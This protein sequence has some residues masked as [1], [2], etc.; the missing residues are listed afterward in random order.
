MK[1]RW[2]F[3]LLS[4]FCTTLYGQTTIGLVAYYSFE[5]SLEDVT[6]N[7]A[8]T[9][10]PSGEVDYDC[11]VEGEALFLDGGGDQVAFIEQSASMPTAPVT[12]EFDTEDF[13]VSM[14]FKSTGLGGTQVLL[15]KQRLDCSIDNAFF[16]RY[17]PLNRTLSVY[18]GESPSQN[19]ILTQRVPADLCWQHIAVVRK[20]GANKLYL[21]ASLIGE[22]TSSKRINIFNDGDLIL[23]GSDCLMGTETNFEGLIDEFRVYNRALDLE[24]IRTLYNQPD[25]II[26]QDTIIFLGNGVDINISNICVDQFAWTPQEGVADPFEPQTNIEPATAGDFIYKL[27]FADN[28][29]GCVAVDSIQIS[30]IDPKDLDCESIFIPNAFTPNNVGPFK[31]ETFGIS[32]PFAIPELLSF[33]IFDR[34][35]NRVFATAD[36]F[37]RWDG[38]YKGTAVNPGVMLYKLQYR[39]NGET[40]FKAGSLTV[41]R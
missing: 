24:E 36:P 38:N 39:C 9:G 34:W 21:N 10:F 4:V 33:E 31:N 37:Q 8:N 17:I 20:A 32:N 3:C 15:A 29:A 26:S 30:V 25:D 41:L 2:L 14:Y 40:V 18:L 28:A 22:I 7:T 23:G 1:K 27:S 35:G 6:G 11:G 12:Q 13:T 19:A 16:I 5:N